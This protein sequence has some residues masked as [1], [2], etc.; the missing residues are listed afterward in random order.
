MNIF[1]HGLFQQQSLLTKFCSF[2]ERMWIVNECIWVENLFCMPIPEAFAICAIHLAASSNFMNERVASWT[3]LCVLFHQFDGSNCVWIAFV[4]FFT[5]FVTLCAYTNLTRGAFPVLDYDVSVAIFVWTSWSIPLAFGTG[6]ASFA[7]IEPIKFLSKFILNL[8]VLIGQCLIV[9]YLFLD[10]ANLRQEFGDSWIDSF[11]FI[12]ASF[13]NT[14]FAFF[15]VF[16][17][18]LSSLLTHAVHAYRNIALDAISIKTSAVAFWNGTRDNIYGFMS[19]F[20]KPNLETD[21]VKFVC[22]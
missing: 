18:I 5:N 11:W 6:A 9:C 22:L 10:F 13:E 12:A 4:V 14:A 7:T 1:G 8:V 15:P 3:V 16:W 19:Q 2:F 20:F 17:V 21:D